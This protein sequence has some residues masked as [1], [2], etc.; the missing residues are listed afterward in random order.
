MLLSMTG[1][2][3]ASSRENGFLI[4]SEVKTVNNRYLKTTIKTPDGFGALEPRID[5]LLHKSVERG[6]V[7][8]TLKLERDADENSIELNFDALERYLTE[9]NRFVKENPDLALFDRLGSFVDFLKLPGVV[10]D[11]S[12]FSKGD[13]VESLWPVIRRTA[14][15]A[16]D[17]MQTMR[18]VEGATTATYLKGN[19]VQLQELV[20]DIKRLAPLEAENYRVRLTERVSK[21]L[22][23]NG[24]VLNPS[25]LIREVAVYTDRV[26]VS[27]EIARFYSHLAQ[28]EETMNGESA[29]GKKLDFI[30]Q[31]MNREANTIGSKASSPEVLQRVVE[32]KS[33][34]ERVREMIQNVE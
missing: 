26:D 11:R 25:D 8:F 13:L 27:E 22:A 28:F 3:A 29:C 20:G 17:K 19:L 18:R 16:L 2:G 6:S 21:V 5:E 15:D 24:A 7:N 14:I 1:F 30:T 10:C 23:E 33:T 34:V 12:N 31:E 32:M 4:S 9:A